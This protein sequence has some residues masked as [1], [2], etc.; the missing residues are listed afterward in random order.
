MNPPL[1][2]PAH[3]ACSKNATFESCPE[4]L[5]EARITS[6]IAAIASSAPAAGHQ[7]LTWPQ[8]EAACKNCPE[9]RDL[10]AAVLAN[11]QTSL[12]KPHLKPY[13]K[14][15][16]ELTLL[17]D[18]VMLNNRIVVLISFRPAILKYIH[19]AHAG[20][21]TMLARTVESVYWPNFKTD[22][23]NIR[24]SCSSCNAHAPSNPALFLP[25]DPALPSYPFQEICTDFF[26]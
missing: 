2:L 7:L 12:I 10:T 6:H 15:F 18:V 21:P 19:T 24:K 5:Y 17:R 11:N 16:P 4:E 3:E 8:L 13:S 22:I 1:G 23:E 20:T 14:V 26:E 25:P 9:Y